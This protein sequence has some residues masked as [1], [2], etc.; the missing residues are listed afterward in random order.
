MTSWQKSLWS[1]A[2]LLCT[3]AA[4]LYAQAQSESPCFAI[5]VRLN[6][7]PV[8]GPQALTFKTKEMEKKSV[9]A[10]GGCFKVPPAVLH[11]KAVDVLFTV[12]GNKVYLSSILSGFFAGEWDIDLADRRFPRDVVLPK[13]ARTREA[14][15]VVFHVGEPE[16]ART[17]TGCRTAF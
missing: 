17:L 7:K 11:E 1:A 3:N 5:H 10:E 13:H 4:N 9:S 2:F 12:P 8:V 15:A 6:G 14:C 16:T